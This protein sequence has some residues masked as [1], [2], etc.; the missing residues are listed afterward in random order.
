MGLDQYIYLGDEYEDFD[1]DY[2]EEIGT[3]VYDPD[4]GELLYYNETDFVHEIA[5]FRKS[6]W[7]H[8]YL[9]RLCEERANRP[10]GNCHYF[11]FSQRDLNNL[12]NTCRE[13]V[14]SKSTKIAKELLPPCK[15]CFF[16][17]YEID[18]YY[19]DDIQDFIDIMQKFE[20]DN[21]VYLYYAW[22]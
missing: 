15:G 14:K 7:L 6:N 4:K 18:E 2:Y 21:N 1:E 5:Y 10:I 16:G 13:V 17:S 8:G 19:F 11:V 9:D 20:E 22:W 3:P 12:L